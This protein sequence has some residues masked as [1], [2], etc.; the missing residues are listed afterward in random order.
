[1]FSFTKRRFILSVSVFL[2]PDFKETIKE[3]TNSKIAAVVSVN[4]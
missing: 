1:M 4:P 2:I 3:L